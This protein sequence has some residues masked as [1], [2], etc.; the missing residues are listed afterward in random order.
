[1]MKKLTLVLLLSLF[2]CSILAKE[3]SENSPHNES[4][5][6]LT[7]DRSSELSYTAQN[8]NASVQERVAALHQ[9][10]DYP[11]QNALVAIT[12]GVRAKQPEIRT[13]AIAAAM[14]YKL[15]YRWRLISPL[16]KDEVEEVRNAAA[17][18][19]AKEFSI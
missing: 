10:A 4:A 1:M 15:D 8:V 5:P 2:A 18:N 16:L 12:R 17:I 3:Q 13:A 14:P 6:S 7:Q 11:S 9:L 19:F